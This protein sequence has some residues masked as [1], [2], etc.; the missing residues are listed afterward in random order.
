VATAFI[1]KTLFLLFKFQGTMVE[2]AEVAAMV[3]NNCVYWRELVMICRIS[4]YSGGSSSEYG[5]YVEVGGVR[6]GVYR[7]QS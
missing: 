2:T 3:S 6:V 7:K 5:A 4:G 1:G